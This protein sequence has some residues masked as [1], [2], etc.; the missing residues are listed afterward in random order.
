MISVLQSLPLNADTPF[1][2]NFEYCKE[3]YIINPCLLADLSDLTDLRIASA[4]K[5]SAEISEQ[6]VHESSIVS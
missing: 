5:S 2:I 3:A 1:K 4:K 6:G